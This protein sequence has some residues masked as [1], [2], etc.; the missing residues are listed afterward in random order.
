MSVSET[1][2]AQF[3]QVQGKGRGP[4]PFKGAPGG[5]YDTCSLD[6]RSLRI[7]DWITR[8]S[9]GRILNVRQKQS[10]AYSHRS[11]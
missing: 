4:C 6:M 10:S 7:Q 9:D 2:G 11:W 1:R 8:L 3:N 5:A